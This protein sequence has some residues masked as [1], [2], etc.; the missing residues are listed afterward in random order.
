MN[1]LNISEELFVKSLLNIQKGLKQRNKF[2][3]VMDEFTDSWYISKIGEDWL[4]T[5]I[6]LL[7]E[8]V[9]DS[10]P[11]YPVIDWWLFEDVE[12]CI[13]IKQKDK[14]I[15]IKVKTPKQLYR[16]FKKYN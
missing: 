14:E 1:Q 6:E 7:R 4:N 3:D 13:W 11:H 5:A 15:K 10:D 9:G 16:Y 2:N 8:A 12:K